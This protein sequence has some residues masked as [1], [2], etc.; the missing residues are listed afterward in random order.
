MFDIDVAEE[1]DEYTAQ[2]DAALEGFSLGLVPGKFL[3]G[4]IPWLRYVPSFFP[5]AGFQKQFAKWREGSSAL[6]NMP[7][8][9]VKEAMVRSVI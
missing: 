8:A 7:F 9:Y 6:R 2:V 1:N 4:A 3:V 5:G